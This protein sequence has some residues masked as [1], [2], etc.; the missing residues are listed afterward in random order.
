MHPGQPAN[1]ARSVT[2]L[3]HHL[4]HALAA[5]ISVPSPWLLSVAEACGDLAGVEEH[6]VPKISHVA[7]QRA[8]SQ[9]HQ[10]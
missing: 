8:L 9:V 6:V 5:D 7:Q 4:G 2:M 10:Q 1:A 3:A